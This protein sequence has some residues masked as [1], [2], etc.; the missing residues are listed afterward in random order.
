MTD[1]EE[2][3]YDDNKGLVLFTIKKMGLQHRTDL[4]FESVYA[5]GLEGLSESIKTFDANKG[6]FSPHA[7]LC[8]RRSILMYIRGDSRRRNLSTIPID[9]IENNNDCAQYNLLDFIRSEESGVER[10]IE[11]IE[12][13]NEILASLVACRSVR[14]QNIFVCKI[15]GY[16]EQKIADS[17]HIDQSSVSYSFKITSKK[18]RDILCKI[19]EGEM[20]PSL[21]N[22]SSPKEYRERFSEYYSKKYNKGRKFLESKNISLLEKCIGV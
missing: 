7:C 13:I 5:S 2:K 10:K 8:I 19:N 9:N 18:I 12:T 11:R 1:Y 17:L 20:F 22:F 6:K 21:N 14:D 4:D 3:L 15:L 16:T